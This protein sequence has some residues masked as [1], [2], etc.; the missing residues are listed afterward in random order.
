MVDP[1]ATR[2]GSLV[3]LEAR[4]PA[5]AETTGPARAAA[6]R[7]YAPG[8]K[9]SSAAETASVVRGLSQSAPVN[10]ARVEELRQAM[11]AGNFPVQV[12]RIATAMISSLK[13]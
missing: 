1:I 4:K 2:L 10:G 6:S 11:A 9:A 3:G 13:P 5:V 8:Q 7:P 12:S